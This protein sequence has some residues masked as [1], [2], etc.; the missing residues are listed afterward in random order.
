MKAKHFFTFFLIA[1]FCIAGIHS[2]SQEKKRVL[3][4]STST[5]DQFSVKYKFGNEK[6]LFRLSTAYLNGSSTNYSISDT[7]NINSG[8]GV[9]IGIE[10]PNNLNEQLTLYYGP[11][12][13][14]DFYN[15]TGS[16]ERIR[17]GIGA[18]GI[19]G[20]AW[21]LNSS[22]RLG[23]EISPGVS[24]EYYKEKDNNDFTTKTFR[25][26]FSNS[27]AEIVLGFEF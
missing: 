12:L 5:F 24:Y 6:Y 16:N 21:H 15:S 23:A 9:G 7:N 20:I 11:E 25:Y 14:T 18:Y 22:I 26:G 4:I 10:F 17:Y 27:G 19:I 13:K 2:Y 1:F 3:E 8:F